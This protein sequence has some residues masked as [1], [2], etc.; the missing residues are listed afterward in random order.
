MLL[1]AGCATP[2]PD[3]VLIGP[4]TV[5]CDP[6]KEKCV[7]TTKAFI[8]GRFLTEEALIKCRAAHHAR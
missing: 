7:L 6:A 4:D 5:S 1:L 2:A 8:Q 3:V